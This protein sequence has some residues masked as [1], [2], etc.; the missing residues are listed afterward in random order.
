MYPAR[1]RIPPVAH[2]TS[3][4]R[5]DVPRPNGSW[6]PASTS[7]ADALS[8]L[9]VRGQRHIHRTDIQGREGPCLAAMDRGATAISI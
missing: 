9:G 8:S 5:A 7:A 4:V 3:N 1:L 6:Q 2:C